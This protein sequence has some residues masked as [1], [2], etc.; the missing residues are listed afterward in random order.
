MDGILTVDKPQSFTS[1]D[2][3]A[4]I[5][6]R[7]GLKK[8]GHAGTLDPMA[9]GLLIILIGSYTKRS[10]EFLNHDKEYEAVMTL[11]AV[12]DTGDAWGSITQRGLRDIPLQEIE[13]VFKRFSGHIDQA[14]P[15]YSAKKVN[16]RKLYELA[17][18]GI[19]VKVEPK[20]VVI[21]SIKI[22]DAKLPKVSFTVRC[23]K[24][25]YVRQL[26]ADIGEALGCGAYM[27]ALRRTAS[28]G[29]SVEGAITV[30]QIK[31]MDAL[32]IKE[33]LKEL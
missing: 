10:S 14:V 5:R 4:L 11:G 27:S 24:G 18:K 20:S 15:A 13:A 17:R 19:E 29:I 8:V 16:G 1:H 6:K 2:V 30:E 3:V 25:T 23:S 21:H 26:C 22:T 28:G 9:T 12:S 33:R 32:S 31:K 7:F